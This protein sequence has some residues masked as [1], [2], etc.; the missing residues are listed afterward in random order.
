MVCKKWRRATIISICVTIAIVVTV[1]ALVAVAVYDSIE[2]KRAA[3]SAIGQ[4]FDLPAPQTL[5]LPSPPTEMHNLNTDFARFAADLVVRLESKLLTPPNQLTQSFVFNS[6][7]GTNNA[8]LL[9]AKTDGH[10]WLVFRG[11]STKE[12]WNKD[13]E[14]QQV[15]FI[16]RVFSSN[17][18]R[19]LYP[20]MSMTGQV[21][22]DVLPP[23]AQVH[24]GFLDVY[25]SM[26]DALM[27]VVE[28]NTDATRVCVTGHSLG[29]ALAQ[30]AAYDIAHTFPNLSMDVV[31]FGCPRVGNVEFSSGLVGLPNLNSLVLIANT[32]DIVT[33]LPL[34]V[35]PSRSS[36]PLIY[37]HPAEAVHAFTENRTTWTANHMMGIY[38]DYLVGVIV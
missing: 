37:V 2:V 13:F 18:R 31:A 28:Q 38:A 8:W 20:K 9:R 15:P 12:E 3:Q 30:I 6:K 34:A 10:I 4:P 26:R 22:A 27:C 36:P 16:T 23:E 35:Q 32:C 24:T 7:Y 21:A 17:T 1:L 25:M 19:V 33:N 29:G 11:T 5:T 14:M